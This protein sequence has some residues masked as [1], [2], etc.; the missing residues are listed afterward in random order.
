MID[1]FPYNEWSEDVTTFWTFGPAGGSGGGDLT[2][3]FV[4]TGLGMLLMVATLVYYVWLEQKKLQA[5]AE[6]LRAAGGAPS[7]PGAGTGGPYVTSPTV[8]P[9]S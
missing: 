2:G 5:Q 1:S 7:G 4:L 3:T 6:F 8:D 9:E